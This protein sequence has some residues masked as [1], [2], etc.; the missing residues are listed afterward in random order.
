MQQD[1][2]HNKALI[3]VVDDDATIRVMVKEV[4]KRFGF[5]V[6]EATNGAA[7]LEILKSTHPD[8]IILDVVMPEVDGFTACA[9]LRRLPAARHTPILMMTGLDDVESIH[10]AYE[11]GATDFI[12]KPINYVILGHRLHY[13]LR[14]KSTL[15]QLRNSER[16]LTNAQR[17]A[18]LGH[19]AWD[20][21]SQRLEISPESYRIFGL[22]STEL[23]ASP[24]SF[25]AWVHPDDQEQVAESFERVLL[26]GTSTSIEH[27]VR[28]PDGLERTV[29][30]E[31][32]VTRDQ[33]GNFRVSGT[34][35]DITERK[36]AEEKLFQMTYFDGLTGLPNRRYV[37]EHLVH[38]LEH[39]K[40]NGSHVAVL[41]LDLDN[42]KRVNDTLGHQTGDRLLDA[43]ANRLRLYTRRS[44]YVS[45]PRAAV[46]GAYL[47]TGTVARLGGDEFVVVLPGIAHAD[48]A[49]VV[50][51]R[52]RESI[53]QPFDIEG[54]Q[55][56]IT[57]SIGIVSYP[58]NGE[59]VETLLQH[60]GAALHDAK[61]RGPDNCQLFC[62]SLNER[63][64]T[65]LSIE[66]GL[67]KAIERDE[68]LVH[69]QPKVDIRTGVTLG[70]EALVRW[71]HPELGI[72][73]PTQFIP[74]AE[75]RDLIAPIGEWVLRQACRQTRLWQQEG[76]APLRVSI[77]LSPKQFKQESLVQ[78]ISD[79]L[80][81]T[82]LDPSL[83]E[84]EVTESVLMEDIDTALA[85]MR[86]LQG[87]GVQLSID[88][89]GTGYS[90]LNY[91]KRFPINAL[92]ID[93]S[94][95]RDI[96]HSQ[97]DAAIVVAIIGLAHN[98][99]LRVVA[100]GAEDRA[101][102]DFLRRHGC[103]QVQGFFFSHPLPE[104]EFARWVRQRHASAEEEQLD[105]FDVPVRG[106][107]VIGQ[108][109]V[110]ELPEALPP[111]VQVLNRTAT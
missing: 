53:A 78:T 86:A 5:E 1:R 84:L 49:A 89:F 19:W 27:R 42:F 47:D 4:V 59:D 37:K 36:T 7:A 54:E 3:L 44:D 77:N 33:T 107:H 13:M 87:L 57:A 103:D 31:L 50:A 11:A 23:G 21:N 6:M 20:S 16:R 85:T 38:L 46:H 70:M 18:R 32:E 45:R 101:Q 75:E 62:K 26:Q 69:Y 82:R 90:S 73:S 17:I 41:S 64:V 60:A 97:D 88:D 25:L 94:F 66:N 29:H 58:D 61:D 2:R 79:V 100:E 15:D 14:A 92:K 111:N 35:Q 108:R 56:F 55:I 106:P 99:H 81:D 28:L 74:I 12:T 51:Q 109:G 102:L 76:L 34:I 72:V 67:R 83:L 22:N 52:V 40:L 110:L 65:R 95:I 24:Q 96:S 10:R 93:R 80:A 8:L 39:A 43:V 105:T 104:Q 9:D 98:L 71:V 48:D 68:L 30:Q 63:A 91:L